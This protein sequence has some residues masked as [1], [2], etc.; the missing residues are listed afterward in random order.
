MPGSPG[1]DRAGAALELKTETMRGRGCAAN[2]SP[3]AGR[4]SPQAKQVVFAEARIEDKKGCLVSRSTGSFLVQ[5]AA[6]DR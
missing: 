3:C 5:R 6:N 2:A 4:S 1:K